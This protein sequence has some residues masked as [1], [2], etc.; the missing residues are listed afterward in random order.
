MTKIASDPERM[1]KA[2]SEKAHSISEEL[3]L[4]ATEEMCKVMV[5]EITAKKLKAIPFSNGAVGRRL[6][7]KHSGV[8]KCQLT[9]R[10]HD[11][12]NS[13]Q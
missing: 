11:V 10:F 5:S 2:K 3:I 13:A 12:C 9:E 6:K 8:I 4:P 1:L 7:I